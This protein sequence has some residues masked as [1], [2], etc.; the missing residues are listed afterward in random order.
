[1]DTDLLQPGDFVKLVTGGVPGHPTPLLRVGQVMMVTNDQSRVAIQVVG[2]DHLLLVPVQQL[3]RDE[4]VSPAH[5]TELSARLGCPPHHWLI[6]GTETAQHWTCQRCGAERV[7]QEAVDGAS[8][9]PWRGLQRG[10]EPPP[11]PG[12]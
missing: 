12:R 6:E 1:M 11:P 4:A 5:M 7:Q 2:R 10:S 8:K 9:D 3:Q